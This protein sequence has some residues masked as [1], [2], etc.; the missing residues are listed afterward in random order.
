M[1]SMGMK[2]EN[3]VRLSKVIIDTFVDYRRGKLP[4]NPVI[5]GTN[6]AKNHRSLQEKIHHQMEQILDVKLPTSDG[7]TV[8]DELS[9]IATKS[10]GH[11]KAALDAPAKNNERILAEITRILAKAEKLYEETRKLHVGTDTLVF[12]NYR[13]RLEFI[14][15]LREMAQHLERDDW[16]DVFDDGFGDVGRKLL[17]SETRTD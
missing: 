5:S 4:A 14:R 10:L 16:V 3:A 8:R 6:A 9:V 1:M 13:A 12:R 11:I 2:S 17:L 15:D 7:H